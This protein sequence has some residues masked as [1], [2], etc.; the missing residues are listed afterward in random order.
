[1]K[2]ATFARLLSVGRLVVILGLLRTTSFS[3]T[4]VEAWGFSSCVFC[5]T[6]NPVYVP[7][8]TCLN[9][10]GQGCQMCGWDGD[11]IGGCGEC[12]STLDFCALCKDPLLCLPD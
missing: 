8:G 12:S 2:S 9:S 10:P 7:P 4:P 1:M 6:G 5:T 3:E 11:W